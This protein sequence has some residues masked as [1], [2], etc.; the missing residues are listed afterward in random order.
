MRAV[1]EKSLLGNNEQTKTKQDSFQL[2]LT[3][4][5]L[6]FAM[7]STTTAPCSVVE[8]VTDLE[9]IKSRWRYAP[10]LTGKK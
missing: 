6:H 2:C 4:Q 8:L 7:A 10:R 1:L 3:V 9:K 5:M